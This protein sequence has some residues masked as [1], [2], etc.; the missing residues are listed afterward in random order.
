VKSKFPLFAF[1]FFVLDR[2]NRNFVNHYSQ[3]T[4]NYTLTMKKLLLLAAVIVTV[5]CGTALAGVPITT[6]DKVEPTDEMFMDMATTAARKSIADG[7]LPCGA[8][9]I[10]NGAWRSTGTAADTLTA[11]ENAIAKSRRQSLKNAVIYTINEPTVK[12]YNTICRYGVDAVYFVNS[13]QD[14]IAK[15]I[16]TEADYDD[17]QIDS[18]LTLVPLK[19]V[20][21]N[22]AAQLLK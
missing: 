15:G 19:Q 5:L 9:V 10:L 16:Y 12:A 2:I 3:Q 21:Y 18:T 7:G 6:V 17:S 14:V 8:V 4:Q 22:D 20:S 13:R 11:E 1:Y